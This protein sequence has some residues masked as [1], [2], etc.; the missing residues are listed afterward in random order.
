MVIKQCVVWCCVGMSLAAC[1]AQAPQAG[2][3]VPTIG[4][5]PAQGGEQEAVT[6]VYTEFWKVSWIGKREPDEQ[7]AHDV[8]DVSGDPIAGRVIE[9][10]RA[11]RASGVALY[12]TVTTR[13]TDVRVD[14]D[15]A[16]VTD[17][18]DASH[19]GQADAATGEPRT[20][21][22]ARNPVRGTLTQ[23]PGQRW[24]V[25]DITYPGGDC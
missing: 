21:G 19:S 11:Q 3:G 23:V 2:P 17:C 10:S 16:T 8:R 7:W 6:A 25:V 13:V 1:S 5:P 12:G 14:G 9:R 15:R 18:Q 20:V 22:V 24:K 4:A